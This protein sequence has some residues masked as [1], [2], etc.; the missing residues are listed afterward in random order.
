MTS[1]EMTSVSSHS[2]GSQSQSRSPSSVQ[3]YHHEQ[4]QQ[5][6]RSKSPTSMS[7]SR[8]PLSSRPKEATLSKSGCGIDKLAF[9]KK[10]HGVESARVGGV[11][12]GQGTE[13][14]DGFVMV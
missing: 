6:L 3:S 2:S 14:V 4:Q 13:I 9:W 12:V 5:D 8:R 11:G 10:L 1:S 7:T